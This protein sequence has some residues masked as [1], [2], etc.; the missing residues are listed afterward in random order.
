MCIL[1]TVYERERVDRT[2]VLRV[3]ARLL[4]LRLIHNEKY[5]QKLFRLIPR[6]FKMTLK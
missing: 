6:F 2:H 3:T 4:K 5:F 1:N